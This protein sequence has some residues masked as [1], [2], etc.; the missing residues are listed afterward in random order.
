MVVVL[1]TLVLG[2]VAALYIARGTS[3][4]LRVAVWFAAAIV[5]HDLVA[6]PVY[7]TADR[8]LSALTGAGGRDLRRRVPVVNH[9]RAPALGSLLL[10]VVFLPQISGQGDGGLTSA[11]GL[12]PGAHLLRWIVTSAVLFA[13]SAAVYAARLL[14][15]HRARPGTSLPG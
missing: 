6:F 10:L 15:S 1:A 8:V 3:S 4:W 14:R 9:L 7:A 12:S 5:L 13:L 2:A 11:S